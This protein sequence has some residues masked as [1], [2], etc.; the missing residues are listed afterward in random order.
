MGRRKHLP[1]NW[2]KLD[3]CRREEDGGGPE[4]E[5][6]LV[7]RWPSLDNVEAILQYMFNDM[8]LLEEALTHHSF[9]DKSFYYEQLEYVGDSVPGHAAGSLTQLRAAI[10]DTE[11]LTCVAVWHGLR[12]YLRHRKPIEEFKRA[13]L[14]YPSSL[15]NVPKALANIVESTIGAVFIDCNF[16]LDT[17]WKPMKMLNQFDVVSICGLIGRLL[18]PIISPSALKQHP[19]TKLHELSSF[20]V[21]VNDQLVGKATYKPKKDI[22]LNR[23]AKDTLEN[24][25]SLFGKE[26]STYEDDRD[27]KKLERDNELQ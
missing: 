10:V 9:T 23:V 26:E 3:L 24:I 18:E 2:E 22:A 27:L 15:I 12:R 1:L 5:P 13:I 6:A 25:G 7:E 14:D 4:P 21:F 16:S 11:K 8:R 17:V 20:I 19:V